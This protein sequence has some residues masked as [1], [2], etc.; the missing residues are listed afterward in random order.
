MLILSLF[1]AGRE[2]VEKPLETEWMPCNPSEAGNDCV[3]CGW[4]GP[5]ISIAG[6]MGH[7]FNPW[8]GITIR[9]I[10]W[11]GPKKI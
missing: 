5:C 9:Q 3:N 8:Q 4:L 7:G 10:M 1:V 11:H 6:G 2:C